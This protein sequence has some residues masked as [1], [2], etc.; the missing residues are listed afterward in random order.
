MFEKILVPL[1]DSETVPVILPYVSYLAKA[2]NL[3]VVLMAVIDPEAE[4]TSHEITTEKRGEESVLVTAVD[5]SDVGRGFL[6]RFVEPLTQEGIQTEIAAAVGEEPAEEILQFASE[7]KCDLIAMATYDRNLLVQ[8]LIGSVTN[9]VLRSGLVPVLAV[10]PK[11]SEVSAEQRAVISTILVPL[12]GSPFAEAVLPYVEYLAE[13][14]MLEIVLVQS[15]QLPILHA[16]VGIG[17]S[18]SEVPAEQFAIMEEDATDY[19]THLVE[20][21]VDNGLNARWV[22]LRGTPSP[23]IAILAESL[24]NSMIALSSHGRSGPARW[25]MGSVAEE[26]IRATGNPVLV[27]PSGLVEEEQG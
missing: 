4:E 2:L 23:G 22:M 14:L 9:D 13:K 12:D 18:A 15:V 11:K 17:E 3:P 1:D 7:N 21:L 8:D 24:P 25:V 26:L 19:L 27:I 10:T 5:A 20:K 16:E 6:R